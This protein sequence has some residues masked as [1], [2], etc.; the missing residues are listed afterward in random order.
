MKS[1]KICLFIFCCFLSLTNAAVKAQVLSVPYVLTVPE[2][3]TQIKWFVDTDGNGFKTLRGENKY[4]LHVD[5]PGVYFAEYNYEDCMLT[6]DYFVFI[7]QNHPFVFPITLNALAD[8]DHYQWFDGEEAI[9]GEE[10]Q[11]LDVNELGEYYALVEDDLCHSES[12]RLLVVNPQVPVAKDD[13]FIAELGKTLMQ[14]VMSNDGPHSEALRV[15]LLEDVSQGELKLQSD[16]NFTYTIGESTSKTVS[17][18]YELCNALGL[19][20]TAVV[21]LSVS[22]RGFDLKEMYIP[23]LLTPNGDSEN[24]EWKIDDLKRFKHCYANSELVIFNRYKKKVYQASNYGL[25]NQWWT[26]VKQDNGAPLP[27][28]TYYYLMVIDGDVAN[29]LNGFIHL[30]Y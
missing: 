19:C 8:A 23:Q 22:C 30:T 14:S 26:G 4:T 7:Y 2:S 6:S 20:D 21:L 5:S 13:K 3:S 9:G 18:S 17:F 16:G 1:I 25:D 12:P 27:A 29:S 28:G 15:K 24:D 10:S 11:S